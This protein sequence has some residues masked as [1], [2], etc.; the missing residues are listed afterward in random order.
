VQAG[1]RRVE[2]AV[3]GDRLSREELFERGFIRRDVNETT[4]DQLIPDILEG[5]VIGL[6]REN[7]GVRHE[8]YS[9][10]A[11][12]SRSDDRRELWPVALI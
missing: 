8:I 2:A 9:I 10:S 7:R 6:C 3:V 4:P 12:D 5:V 1:R 11:R